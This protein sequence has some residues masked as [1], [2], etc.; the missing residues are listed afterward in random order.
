MPSPD[1]R[2]VLSLPERTLRS[3]SALS[4]GI[5]YELSHVTLPMGVRNMALYRATA[6]I[7]LRFLIEELGEVPGIYPPDEYFSRKFLY[8][9]VLGTGIELTSIATFFVSPVWV[10]AALGDATK[11]GRVLTIEI[12]DALKAA[13]LIDP[14]ASVATIE[15]LL[16]ALDR[17]ASHAALAV[18]MPPLD[19]KSLRRELAQ[20]RVELASLPAAELPTKEDIERAW[21]EI[22]DAA[23]KSNRSVFAVSA[24]M[25]ISAVRRVPSDL[26]W[27]SKATATAAKRTGQ[28]TGR[29]LLDHYSAAAREISKVGFPE[30][31]GSELRPY[32]VGA[33]RQMLPQ[34]KSWTERMIAKL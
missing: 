16:D 23:R 19:V 22:A 20:F 29:V 34:K 4:G 7:T 11:V 31:W 2:Y 18:N 28:V 10:L 5:L 30:Y 21:R 24:A 33:I 15:Q 3:V 25:G 26:W 13:R 12:A 1:F 6:G 27:L 8:R 17:T 14:G 9:Y 32:A